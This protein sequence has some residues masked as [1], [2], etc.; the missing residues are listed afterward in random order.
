MIWLKQCGPLSS[1]IME[2]LERSLKLF[3]KKKFGYLIPYLGSKISLKIHQIKTVHPIVLYHNATNW[4][5]PWAIL[6]SKKRHTHRP[7]DKQTEAITDR[8]QLI[9]RTNLQSRGV[10]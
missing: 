3:W 2:K 4:E 6:K 7:N 9:Y 10:Q 1:T 5:D 8:Q